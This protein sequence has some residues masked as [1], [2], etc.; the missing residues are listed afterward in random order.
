MS[1]YFNRAGMSLAKILFRSTTRS[2]TGQFWA[3]TNFIQRS[4][5]TP[6]RSFSTGY[7]KRSQDITAGC[8]NR[9]FPFAERTPLQRLNTPYLK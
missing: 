5:S 7:L 4:F 8:P 6:V 2:P 1:T 9:G 3:L